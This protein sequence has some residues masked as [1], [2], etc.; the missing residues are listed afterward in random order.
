M[1]DISQAAD[2]LTSDGLQCH[3]KPGQSQLQCVRRGLC[4]DTIMEHHG[5]WQ[6]DPF[7]SQGE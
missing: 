6:G 5:E 7:H 4:L 2:R 3:H 1:Y